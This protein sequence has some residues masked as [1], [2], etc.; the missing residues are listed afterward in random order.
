MSTGFPTSSSDPKANS[1]SRVLLVVPHE[2]Y[3]RTMLRLVQALIDE[4][5]VVDIALD[6][7][8]RVDAPKGA[9]AECVSLGANFLELDPRIPFRSR[10]GTWINGVMGAEVHTSMSQAAD[11]AVARALRRVGPVGGWLARHKLA[12]RWHFDRSLQWS[13]GSFR[14]VLDKGRYEFVVFSPGVEFGTDQWEWVDAGR[15]C[16]VPTIL[17]VSSWDNLTNKSTLGNI[18]D[19][20]L[21]WSSSQE[22]E[23]EQRHRVDRSR[24]H[25]IGSLALS[26]HLEVEGPA[27]P[28]RDPSI[29]YATS[30]AFLSPTE[31]GHLRSWWSS[32]RATPALQ[33][34]KII[35]RLHPN[36]RVSREDLSFLQADAA[37]EIYG[38]NIPDTAESERV[39]ARQLD[40]SI[41]V[42]GINTSAFVDAQARGVPAL[43]VDSP[44]VAPYQRGSQHFRCLEEHGG[45]QVEAMGEHVAR[46]AG[47]LSQ[48]PVRSV[49]AATRFNEAFV[50]PADP[51]T[52][53]EAALSAILQARSLPY[54]R[55]G[56]PSQAV[57]VALASLFWA[58]HCAAQLFE[59]IQQRLLKRLRV[60]AKRWRRV[61]NR[62]LRSARAPLR[63]ASVRNSL[64][65]PA[66]LDSGP[67]LEDVAVSRARNRNRWVEVWLGSTS[68]TDGGGV[69]GPWTA[70]VGYEALYWTPLLTWLS[71]QG[72][73]RD[74][75]PISRG[76]TQAWY[77]EDLQA[78][79]LEIF[80]HVTTAEFSANHFNRVKSGRGQKAT[81]V[82]SFD[83]RLTARIVPRRRIALSQTHFF[84]NLRPYVY[85]HRGL[86]EL[87]SML[88]FKKILPGVLDVPVAIGQALPE[89]F[90]AVSLYSRPSLST[91]A[92]ASMNWRP[93][94]AWSSGLPLVNVNTG[95]AIDEHAAWS[96]P[97][98]EVPAPLVGCDASTN[99]GL[100]SELISRS[101]GLI[102]THGGTC[103][104]GIRAGKPVLAL[105]EAGSWI[106]PIHTSVALHAARECG[107]SFSTL[108]V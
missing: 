55:R 56:C 11:P 3:L 37:V 34:I 27:S 46:L 102:A 31:L 60:L 2:G 42:V 21:V 98:P 91:D 105:Q 14:E 25:V 26:W 32:V 84:A 39:Y 9:L 50:F 22:R 35:V 95:T 18:P 47:L 108:F 63:W 1:D 10:C 79:Y 68:S 107:S 72:N 93:L 33:V 97:W 51:R 45:V 52:P 85:G 87:L 29:L 78:S 82:D 90:I 15:K 57:Y 104:V 16:Q 81:T 92:L 64:A 70:E 36:G 20:L 75:I 62:G 44:A 67:P 89:R 59:P 7:N 96:P 80:D 61:W 13:R 19:V 4:R 48:W 69:L 99:L 41:A 100:Q 49:E 53:P 40:E 43:A 24:T 83:L 6:P 88:E 73:L 76:T 5:K 30:S 58:A 71:S 8:R 66:R 103:Y 65:F 77:P 94:L 23:A 86:K 74:D 28:A 12:S 106:N 101:E 17:A 38:P 54:N